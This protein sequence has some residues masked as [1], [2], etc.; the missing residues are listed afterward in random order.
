MMAMQTEQLFITSIKLTSWLCINVFPLSST[1]NNKLFTA[2]NATFKLKASLLSEGFVAG[3]KSSD[4][5]V[6]AALQR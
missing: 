1:I 4:Q 3:P 2:H 6:S 5:I